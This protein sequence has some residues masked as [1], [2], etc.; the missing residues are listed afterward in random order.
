MIVSEFIPKPYKSLLDS[1]SVAYSSPSNIALVKYWGKKAHQIPANPSISFTLNNCKTLT[2]I[3]FKKKTTKGFS[4]EV[5]LEGVIQKEF[6]PKIKQF[7]QRIEVYLPFLNH[8][9][10]SFKFRLSET[11]DLIFSDS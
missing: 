3:K 8:I 11:T 1:G 9:I 6:K 10:F 7:F 2:T 5:Y 4:F